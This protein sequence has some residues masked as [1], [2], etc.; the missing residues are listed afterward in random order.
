MGRG[1][2]MAGGRDPVR[3]GH[4]R[5]TRSSR[6]A[7]VVVAAV[8]LSACGLFGGGTDAPSSAPTAAGSP[9]PTATAAPSPTATSTDA[10]ASSPTS[11]P[12]DVEP[13][14]VEPTDDEPTDVA[15]TDVE[16]RDV[17]TGAGGWLGGSPPASVVAQFSANGLANG[18]FACAATLPG[19][20]AAP[21][22]GDVFP[23]PPA[24]VES[25]RLGRLGAARTGLDP[26]PW[27]V[28]AGRGETPA[29]LPSVDEV[30][31]VDETDLDAVVARLDVVP[32]PDL[33]PAELGLSD[34]LVE[35]LVVPP[36]VAPSEGAAA[37]V[38]PA[39]AG[40]SD[41]G[42]ES[43][44]AP[45]GPAP[46][47]PGPI[48]GTPPTLRG[49]DGVV[50]DLSDLDGEERRRLRVAAPVE[51]AGNVVGLPL[52]PPDERFDA[53]VLW[54]NQLCGDGWEPGSF[55]HVTITD[56]DGTVVV[57]TFAQ[58][59]EDGGLPTTWVPDPDVALG[60]AVVEVDDGTTAV[61]DTVRVVPASEPRAVVLGEAEVSAGDVVRVGV[62]GVEPSA[63]IALQAYV[64]SPGEWF[65]SWEWV[66][67]V[68]VATA[69]ADGQAIVE[70]PIA[71]DHPPGTYCLLLAGP[72]PGL[73]QTCSNAGMEVVS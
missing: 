27:V 29:R 67:S 50:V 70:V 53:E 73:V 25:L 23:L 40:S 46:T 21:A 49:L 3:G 64:S 51:E 48:L 45:T 19:P 34:E 39:D 7:S 65:G 63:D 18:I 60:T 47:D 59:Q 43:E 16:T 71:A 69:D 6:G 4:V 66:G 15:P 72:T 36:T 57:D 68:P 20:D 35:G 24:L 42:T 30:P 8:S 5:S 1:W 13:T 2:T 14:D 17:E 37:G 58:V 31:E 52:W 41:N 9:S 55:V 28:G 33:R 44:S 10:T 32:I 54:P 26:G 61:D 62:S 22:P 38:D 12:R 11:A 56:A